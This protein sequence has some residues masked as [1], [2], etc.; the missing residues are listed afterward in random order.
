VKHL[1]VFGCEAYAHKPTEARMKLKPKFSK[2][3]FVGYNLES[4][5]INQ[6][7]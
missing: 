6:L 4:K 2:C 1:W 5:V 7:F 3:V